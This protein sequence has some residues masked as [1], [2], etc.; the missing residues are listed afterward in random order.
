MTS[1]G[2]SPGRSGPGTQS[3]EQARV[4]P[5]SQTRSCH[6][7]VSVIN[8][9]G[10]R[11]MLRSGG[12]V[13]TGC[14][15]RAW[16]ASRCAPTCSNLGLR[17]HQLLGSLPAAPGIAALRRPGCRPKRPPLDDAFGADLWSPRARIIDILGA[18]ALHG[19]RPICDGSYSRATVRRRLCGPGRVVG[20]CG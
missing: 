18:K 5:K 17:P 19:L 16:K 20:S 11:T 12:R 9:S 4:L 10:R 3:D 15:P 7:V 14:C 2:P 8:Q 13:A 1:R 6:R